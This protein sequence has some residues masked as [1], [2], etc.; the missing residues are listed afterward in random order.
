MA[1][2]RQAEQKN[3]VDEARLPG[4]LSLLTATVDTPVLI[5]DPTGAIS[6]IGEILPAS[7]SSGNGMKP[8]RIRRLK[9]KLVC[10]DCG[11]GFRPEGGSHVIC[12]VCGLKAW[13]NKRAEEYK[14]LVSMITGP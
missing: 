14:T 7:P 4:Q 13:G 3:P 6:R 2:E 8:R 1:L 9:D 12:N 5:Q 10:L 11:L